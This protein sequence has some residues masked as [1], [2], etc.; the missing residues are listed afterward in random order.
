MDE[1]GSFGEELDF[2][3]G[4]QVLEEERI[5]LSDNKEESFNKM[6]NAGVYC[7]LSIADKHSKQESI[8]DELQYKGL[9]SPEDIIDMSNIDDF[10]RILDK[11]RF[12]RRKKEYIFNFSEWWMESPLPEE[13]Y[14]DV[15]EDRER[16]FELRDKIASSPSKNNGAPGLGDCKSSFF[17]VKCGYGNVV[18]I[19]IV[20]MRYL[21]ENGYDVK[22]PDYRKK[23]GPSP[24]RYR[25]LEDEFIEISEEHNV[26]PAVLQATIWMEGSSYKEKTLEEF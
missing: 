19:D 22:V 4:R 10:S 9:N 7:I 3:L 1:K 12:P 20:M 18:P 6:F 2:D 5:D 25:E 8:Y 23:S 13:I 11:A 15:K 26:E 21:D 17:L 24:K 16:E 14:K